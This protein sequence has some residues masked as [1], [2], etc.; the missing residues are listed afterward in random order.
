MMTGISLSDR[1]PAAGSAISKQPCRDRRRWGRAWCLLFGGP[2]CEF[3]NARGGG[4][5]IF[6]CKRCGA[7]RGLVEFAGDGEG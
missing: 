2:A 7:V 5:I 1:G 6:R 3:D 4:P